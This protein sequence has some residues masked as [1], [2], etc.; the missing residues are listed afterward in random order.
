MDWDRDRQLISRKHESL[1]LVKKKQHMQ[2]VFVRSRANI[3]TENFVR[4][5]QSA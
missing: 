2:H 1:K 3:H 4:G 5:E